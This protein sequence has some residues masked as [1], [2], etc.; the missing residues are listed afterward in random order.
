MSRYQPQKYNKKQLQLQWIN[1]LVHL[2]D[3]TCSCDGPL[4]HTVLEIF[5][6]EKNLRFTKEEKNKIQQCLSTTGEENI[7][8]E[9]DVL[10]EGDLEE[11][12]STDFG[13]EKDTAKDDTG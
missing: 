9:D 6:Q 13:E 4:E 7:T 10:G 3:L 5:N 8:H 12:F 2:H 11:L 1:G